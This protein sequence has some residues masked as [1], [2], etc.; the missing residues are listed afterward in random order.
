MPYTGN[1]PRIEKDKLRIQG[2]K[3]CHRYINT[4]LDLKLDSLNP[5]FFSAYQTAI[6]LQSENTFK[7]NFY[8]R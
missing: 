1:Y 5:H 4:H 3:D 7:H 8:V 2:V 6:K